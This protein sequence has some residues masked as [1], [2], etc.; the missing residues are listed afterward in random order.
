[1]SKLK[2]SRLKSCRFHPFEIALCGSSNLGKTTLAEK[3]VAALRGKF[4]IGYL[5]SDAH[6][7][8]IDKEGKDT[9]RLSKAGAQTVAINDMKS[10]ARVSHNPPNESCLKTQFLNNDI[11]IVEGYKQTNIPKLV[12][13]D[14]RAMDMY[15][16]GELKN[17]LGFVD[18]TAGK[19]YIDGLPVFS[20]DD[21]KSIASFLANRLNK[22]AYS[23]P[24]Y[25]LVLAGGRSARMGSDKGALVYEGAPQS[26]RVLSMLAK[27]CEKAF[28]SCRP[29]QKELPHLKSLP[30]ITDSFLG[31]G[32]NSGILSAMRE[33]PEAAWMV[34]AC[35]LPRFSL[36]AAQ[37]LA[38]ER[39]P[40]K[41]ATCFFNEERGWP[42]PLCA[43]Y[44]PKA[45]HALLSHMGLGINCPRKVLANENIKTVAPPQASDIE[46]ANTQNER[47]E[48]LKHFETIRGEL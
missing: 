16:R 41:T 5:K 44:E 29:E 36:K 40:F 25:G 9:W 32:P 30:A 8:Q 11:L 20:R 28:V 39:N 6:K 27:V 37:T 35:D 45:W 18:R 46:N 43:V 23:A 42:E 15:A 26:E 13:C 38:A 17:V 48:A 14:E 19:E 33:F 31:V 7:Y 4:D 34:V 2:P 24:L 12:F 3:L 21:A 1:M 47:A 22:Q 10:F